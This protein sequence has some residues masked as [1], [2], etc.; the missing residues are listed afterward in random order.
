MRVSLILIVLGAVWVFAGCKSTQEELDKGNTYRC[1]SCKEVIAWNYDSAGAP[2]SVR[3]I[4]H[5]CP[6]CKKGWRS[7]IYPDTACAEC[8][9]QHLNCPLCQRHGP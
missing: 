4:R 6:T 5:E 8:R 1:P 2:T 7:L 9:R 3:S